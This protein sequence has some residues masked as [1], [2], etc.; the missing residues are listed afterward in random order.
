MIPKTLCCL[1]D[2]NH[3]ELQEPTQ[4]T[5]LVPQDVDICYALGNLQ[6]HTNDDQQDVSEWSV[7]L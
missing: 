7:S 6:S 2:D 5:E 1:G 3:Q 4:S